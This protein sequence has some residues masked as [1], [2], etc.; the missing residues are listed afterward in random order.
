LLAN[1]AKNAVEASNGDTNMSP[2]PFE[3]STTTHVISNDTN[4]EGYNDALQNNIAVVTVGIIR[5]K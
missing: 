5:S 3:A 1:G 4:F 2:L